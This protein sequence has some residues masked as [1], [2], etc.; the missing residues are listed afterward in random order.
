M[1]TFP[2]C[3][4]Q[5]IDVSCPYYVFNIIEMYTVTVHPIYFLLAMIVHLDFR[6]NKFEYTL[7]K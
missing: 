5:N 2:I 3:G 7:I 4:Y 6:N 1:K